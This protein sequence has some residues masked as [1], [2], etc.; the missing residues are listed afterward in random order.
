MAR[1][2]TQASSSGIV[3]LKRQLADPREGD[4]EDD[5]ASPKQRSLLA[6]A[7]RLLVEISLPKLAVAWTMLLVVPSLVLG[8]APLLATAWL[9]SASAHIVA[10]TEAGAVLV[11]V[12]ISALGWLAWRPLWRIAEDNF[13]SLNALVVQPGYLL[14]SEM[15][16]HLAERALGRQLTAGTRA[17]VRGASSAV[18]AVIM[19][20]CAAAILVV[21]WPS[22]R[23]IGTVADIVA[24]HRLI[25]PAVANAIILVSGYFAIASLFWGVADASMDQ[26]SDL[27]TFDAGPSQARSWRVAHLSDLHVVGERY[28]FRIE[29]GRAGP[30]GNARMHRVLARLAEIHAADPL[31]IV[32]IT[33][34]MTDTGRATEWAEFL[35]AIAKYPALVGRMIL[36]PGNHDVNIVD[37]SN[38]ARLDLPL[39]PTK[40]LRQMR[41]LSAI[42][43]VQGDRAH[44]FDGDRKIRQTLNQALAPHRLAVAKFAENGGFRH[45]ISLGRIYHEQFPMILPPQE[46]DG[47]GVAILNSNAESHFSFTNALG[48]VSVEQV[49]R[50]A[51]AFRN[52]PRAIWIVAL[53]HHLLEYPMPVAF[54][55]RIGTALVNG[56][57]FVRKLKPF[58][59]RTVVMHGHRH[60]DWIGTS[61]L[62]KIISAPSPVMGADDAP[63]HFHIHRF[64]AGPDGR[65]RLLAPEQIE[66]SG[67]GEQ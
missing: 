43:L 65:M 50:I 29:S 63:T 66:I 32:L 27:A 11:L 36:L 3:D 39:S 55:E 12:A 26:P 38:P 18:A 45:S 58:A 35:D 46:A 54:S 9:A 25:V 6:M 31:D 7:G 48:F 8:L 10:I 41:T 28:G 47:L 23:W 52:F 24:L 49:R 30:R 42:S 53:H 4:I 33:G 15:L 2:T 44:V 37:R 17:R 62:L 59:G 16:R 57:W 20:G 61:G 40:R 22:S 14:G 34:D 56:S 51:S 19:C 60:I 5:L 64:V 1:S 21:V 13:W 67:S